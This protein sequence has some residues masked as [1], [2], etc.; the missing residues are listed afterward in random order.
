MSRSNPTTQNPNPSQRWLEWSG[1]K[2]TLKYYDKTTKE[3]V[4]ISGKFTFLLLDSLSSI[5]GWHESSESKIFSN[6]VRDTRADRF[7]VKSFKGGTIA[8]GFYADIK[9]RVKAAGGKFTQNLYIAFKDGDALKIG[10]ISFSGAALMEWMDFS[11]GNRQAL[12]TEAIQID[13]TKEGKKGSVKF[14]VPTF[15][16]IGVSPETNEQAVALDKELQEYLK[17]YLAQKKTEQAAPSRNEYGADHSYGDE[18]A[19]KRLP[20]PDD[21]DDIPF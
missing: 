9:D 19:P 14:K 3:E 12:L 5:K 18:D 1:Q 10:T 2:G 20:E 15:A 4:E 11:K 17:G 21:Y 8:E 6:E 13:G 7:L 16:T